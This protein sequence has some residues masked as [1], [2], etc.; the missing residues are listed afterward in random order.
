MVLDVVT[1]YSQLIRAALLPHTLDKSS[2]HRT[3][4]GMW[5]AFN[6]AYSD[7]GNVT[8]APCSSGT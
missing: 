6:G 7:Q 3:Q 1:I 2:P 4:F 5:P 8:Q